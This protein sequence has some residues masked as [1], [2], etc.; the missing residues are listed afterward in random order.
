MSARP[1][2]LHGTK[3]VLVL[4]SFRTASHPPQFQ[5]QPRDLVVA[6]NSYAM[7]VRRSRRLWMGPCRMFQRL[8]GLFV[9]RKVLLLAVLLSGAVCMRRSI[10]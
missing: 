6:E 5:R 9:P 1:Q 4:R 7:S 8:P 2:Y 10:V 3:P